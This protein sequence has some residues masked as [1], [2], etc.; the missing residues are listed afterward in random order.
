MIQSMTGYGKT[1]KVLADKKITVEIK[2]LNSKNLDMNTRIPSVYREK[3][4]EI[5]KILAKNLMRGKI[6]FSIY[7]E[8]TGGNASSVINKDI[9]SGYMEQL[10][11]LSTGSE[12]LLSIVMRLPDVLKAEREEFNEEEWNQVHEMIMETIEK[13]QEF[14]KDE[15]KVLK[16]DFILRLNNIQLMLDEI[17][18]IDTERLD[19]VKE[20]LLKAISEIEVNYDE[21]RY[22][23]ELLYYLEKLDITEEKV[24]LGNHLD[25]FKK[26]LESEVSNGKKLAFI[27]QEIGREIN[28]IG[29]KSNY[30]PMQKLVVQM[31]DDLEKIKEQLLNIL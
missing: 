15:G 8:N 14:R 16:E 21:N 18:K 4:I 26:E 22:E 17:L 20:K 1:N 30:A 9:V 3:D 13:L 28:T 27:S 11:E 29:S 19:A 23:Q 5:R 6:E 10:K 25:Y 31:K 2:S 12:D 7:V 24:R